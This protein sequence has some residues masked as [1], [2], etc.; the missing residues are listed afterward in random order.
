ME[1][2]VNRIAAR[3]G[4]DKSKAMELIAKSDKKRSNYYNY[5]TNK[6]WGAAGSYDLCINS[7]VVGTDGA[8]DLIL[9]FIDLEKAHKA[10]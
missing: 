4:I 3:D 2:K 10:R 6:R 9:K 1:D 8:V 7:S 5:Y